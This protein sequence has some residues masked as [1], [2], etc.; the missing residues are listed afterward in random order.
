MQA[1]GREWAMTEQQIAKTA[2]K[3]AYQRETQ[4]LMQETRDRAGGVLQLEDVW[5]L[6]DFLS[7]RRHDIDGKYD[8]DHSSLVFVLARLLKEGWLHADELSG[9]SPDKCAKVSAL[10]RM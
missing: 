3:Q 9:I 6:H 1:I 2:L 5:R 7:A 10:S 8:D 4:A